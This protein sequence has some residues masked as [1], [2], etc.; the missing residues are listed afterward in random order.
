[1]IGAA[2]LGGCT[3]S[4]E[5]LEFNRAEEASQKGD[6]PGAITHYRKVV[7]R[8]VKTP[9]AIQSAKEAARISHYQLKKP[10]DAVAFYKHVILYSSDSGDRIM[11]QK[12][13][14][15]LHFTQTLDYKQA[16]V[17]YSR[18]L[19]LPHSPQ[20]DFAYRM[21]I[22]RS[23]FYLSNF[24][25]AQVEIDSILSRSYDKDLLFDAILLK[26]NVFLTMKKLDEAVVTLREL[27]TKYPER[28]KTETIGLVLAVAYEEQ[29][30]FA[31]AIE[32]LESIKDIYPKR[33]FIDARIKVLRERQSYLPGAKGL[34]K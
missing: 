11:A 32:T 18:L 16:V 34:K 10:A 20:D 8:Y 5:K 1:M 14:A 30:N 23:Y 33:N 28:S 22:A 15:D 27:T 29:K 3:V 21:T 6:Y 4:S 31:K 13:L 12:K 9:L 2:A 17:E 19:D 26:A 24:Y 25:Q 7:D